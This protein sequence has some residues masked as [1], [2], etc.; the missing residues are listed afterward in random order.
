MVLRASS[1]AAVTTLVWS[2]RLK[3]SF[4]DASRTRRLTA[5]TSGSDC[6]GT[7][8]VEMTA[9]KGLGAVPRRYKKFHPG[10]YIQSGTNTRQRETQLDEGNGDG[11]LHSN[12]YGLRIKHTRHAGDIGQHATDEGIN[13]LQTRDVDQDASGLGSSNH[14]REVILQGHG[15]AIVHVHLNGDQQELAH[16]KDRNLFQAAL[17]A[18]LR[19]FPDKGQAQALQG[20]RE[21]GRQRSLGRHVK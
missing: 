4:A 11:G 9:I 8:S 10:V 19:C 12:H 7:V 15:Q 17:L 3:P 13:D 6:T 18:P 1:L 20:N 21:G 2:T 16:L 5:T 14:L